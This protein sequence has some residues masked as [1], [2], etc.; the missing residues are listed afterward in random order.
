MPTLFGSVAD[1]FNDSADDTFT[2]SAKMTPD[3]REYAAFM[4]RIDENAIKEAFISKLPFKN[5]EKFSLYMRE[6][7]SAQ[8]VIRKM[9]K[10]DLIFCADIRNFRLFSQKQRK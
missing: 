10:S 1:D 6:L 9:H 8:Q 7:D 5:R 4:C 3:F 2:G